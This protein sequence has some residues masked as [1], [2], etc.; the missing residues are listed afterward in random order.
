M[1]H[2]L[3]GVEK[4]D[5]Y[6]G[7]SVRE[8]ENTLQNHL[9]NWYPV[10][11]DNENGGYYTNFEHNWY[12]S[13]EQTKMLVTQ[14]RGLWTAAKAANKYPNNQLYQ[15][16]A[17]HGYQFI[18]TKMW[19]K[20]DGGFL[21]YNQ[22]ENHKQLHKLLYA[23]AFALFSIAEYA[24]T[25]PSKEVLKWLRRTFN[26]IDSTAHDDIYGGYYNII[27]DDEIKADNPKNKTYIKNLGWGNPE[28]KD[29]NTSI[30]LLEAFTTLH[31]VMPT[32]KVKERLLEMLVLVRDTMTRDN[33][34][35]KLY[36][37][38][39]WHPI[40]HS[41]S[42]RKYILH[43]QNIDHVSFGHNIE[44]AYLIIDAS[45]ELYGQVDNKTLTVAKKLTNHSL[46]YGFDENYYGLYDRGYVFDGKMEIINPQKTWWSQFEA[47]HTLALM[48]HYFPDNEEYKTAFSKMWTYINDELTD[49]EYGGFYNNGTD[50]SVNE[51]KK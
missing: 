29:Q 40:D 19:D 38:R 15:S 45:K 51:K 39:N 48:H 49:H 46:K 44:I 13:D 6:L 2:L 34:S 8:I 27:L 41:D 18:T 28:W 1:P 36:F 3:P 33:G 37:T 31:K 47:W 21:L 26:W 24:K 25:E 9:N 14:A 11:I 42:T 17:R 10:I 12:K 7:V 23:N 4:E 5:S 30:H 20:K 16:S 50:T 43:N 22:I 35:L 32:P